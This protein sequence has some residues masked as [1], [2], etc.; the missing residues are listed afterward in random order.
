MILFWYMC[1]CTAPNPAW[2]QCT[3]LRVLV[4]VFF[5]RLRTL[6]RLDSDNQQVLVYACCSAL[7]PFYLMFPHGEKFWYMRYLHSS[8]PGFNSLL[9]GCCF[10]YMCFFHSS[11]P[12]LM[13]KLQITMFRYMRICTAPNLSH[14]YNYFHFSFGICVIYT[15][16]NQYGVI[17]YQVLRFGICNIC[18][19]PNLKFYISLIWTMFWYMCFFARLRTRVDGELVSLNVLV[20]AYFV[21]L[22]TLMW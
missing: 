16:P 21:Q 14:R 2:L 17:Y 18:T 15:A 10:W 9:L 5:A 1:I 13:V 11:E 19:A 8:E 12:H 6:R 22:R 4:Y 7:N 20:Y 3:D